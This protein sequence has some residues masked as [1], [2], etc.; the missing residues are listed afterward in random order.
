MST[1]GDTRSQPEGRE[2][3]ELR[4]ERERL[5]AEVARL[6]QAAERNVF[7]RKADLDAAERSVAVAKAMRDQRNGLIVELDAALA[8]WARLEGVVE[9]LADRNGLAMPSLAHHFARVVTER[10]EARDAVKAEREACA[11]LAENEAER[12]KHDANFLGLVELGREATCAVIA[13][14]IRARGGR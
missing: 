11:L 4:A 6:T 8:E 5:K 14:A 7:E 9:E 10:N 3:D 13:N 1:Y 12:I 2:I